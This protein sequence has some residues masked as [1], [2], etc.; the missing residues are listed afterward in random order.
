MQPES[1]TTPCRKFPEFRLPQGD[2][3]YLSR[4]FSLLDGAGTVAIK[5]QSDRRQFGRRPVFKSAV[6]VLDDGRKVTA[7]II[8]LS[9]AGA[10]IKTS[11]SNLVEPEFD[12]EIA[13][14]DFVVRCKLVHVDE[15]SIGAQFIKPPRRISWRKR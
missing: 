6:I 13:D 3:S 15:V 11:K 4:R 5:K 8:D 2:S 10:R 14:D 7:S 9:S 12:L 1:E